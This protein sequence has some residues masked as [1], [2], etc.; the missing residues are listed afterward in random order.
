[1]KEC[2][3]CLFS[4]KMNAR[5]CSRGLA[6]DDPDADGPVADAQTWEAP[7][8]DLRRDPL[9]VED[10]HGGEDYDFASAFPSHG[11]RGPNVYAPFPNPCVPGQI[12]SPC[13]AVENPT[14]E[15]QVH[16]PFPCARSP[17]PARGPSF[18]IRVRRC[19]RRTRPFPHGHGTFTEPPSIWPN[20]PSRSVC[21][22]EPLP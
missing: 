3:T 16:V 4:W 8:E 22:L 14:P 21:R 1:M 18:P 13:V 15:F 12:H 10:G 6:P 5:A 2:S 11:V 9:G 7:V 19:D 20:L 17:F